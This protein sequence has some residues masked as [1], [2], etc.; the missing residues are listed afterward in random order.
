MEFLPNMI[1]RANTAKRP[2]DHNVD[3]KRSVQLMVT[4]KNNAQKTKQNTSAGFQPQSQTTS[5]NINSTA[6]FIETTENIS[7]TEVTG[8]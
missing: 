5:G 7:P 6:N 4:E 3:E 8:I 1:T 2:I